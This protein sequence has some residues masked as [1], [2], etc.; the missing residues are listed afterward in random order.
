M[1]NPVTKAAQR[2]MDQVQGISNTVSDQL[3][4]F[5]E[6]STNAGLPDRMKQ[7]LKKRN[8]QIDG[9]TGDDGWTGSEG[10]V[11][12]E[13]QDTASKSAG[14]TINKQSPL[15]D[16][17][18]RISGKDKKSTKE[19]QQEAFSLAGS[20]DSALAL[21]NTMDDPI[22]KIKAMSFI[23]NLYGINIISILY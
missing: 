17:I 11:T 3:G 1:N 20:Y 19:V 8:R 15:A 16:L 23:N 7:Q 14:F 6:F 18:K 13:S 4:K 9:P 10:D 12:V 22:A 2:G 5:K 21:V